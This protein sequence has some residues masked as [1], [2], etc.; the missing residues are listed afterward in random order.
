M[1]IKMRLAILYLISQ[2][3]HITTVN[4]Q[5]VYTH[6]HMSAGEYAFDILNLGEDFISVK[7]I[8]KMI[9]ELEAKL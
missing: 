2:Y 7:K 6:E 9:S 1:D 3:M 5:K 4:G 8:D